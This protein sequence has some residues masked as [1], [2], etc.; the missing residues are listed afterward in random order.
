M[1]VLC[2]VDCFTAPPRSSVEVAT[3]PPETLFEELLIAPLFDD[4]GFFPPT[5]RDKD[6]AVYPGVAVVAVDLAVVDYC[7][8]LS[9]L[10]RKF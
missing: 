8:Y 7:Y 5:P 4:Y 6:D 10:V 3:E 2:C 1:A 9:F